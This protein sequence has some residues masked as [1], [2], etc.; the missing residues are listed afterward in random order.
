MGGAHHIAIAQA[1]QVLR[2]GG[3]V[4]FPTETVY[5]LG[6]DAESPA[7]V[8]KIFAAKGRPSAHPLIVHLAD[9][10]QLDAWAERV[11]DRAREL[12]MR[13]WP[14]PLTI[15]LRRS[16]RVCDEVTGGLPTVGLRVPSHPLAHDLLVAFGG[17]IAA[18][19]ANR[20]GAVSPTTADH[21]RADLGDAVDLVL[22]GGPCTV[23]LESTIVDLSRGD[24]EPV[25]LRA[26]G[27]DRETIAAILGCNVPLAGDDAVAS[28]G[29]LPSHYAPRAP[30]E[31]VDADRIDEAVRAHPRVKVG[32]LRQGTHAGPPRWH[33]DLDR[34]EVELGDPAAVAHDLY[35]TL[36]E[37]D[38]RGCAVIIA[39]LPAEQGLGLAIAD[40]LRKAAAPR[41]A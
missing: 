30:V 3:L 41:G 39:T 35:A 25:L 4:A 38:A 2:S 6:A 20:F 17:G 10:A 8:R 5:G 15:V 32:V 12:A 7:A 27:I 21:V 26:G 29:R 19:S 18:P 37:L 34:V 33:E 1:V 31:L 23:G 9:V 13:C 24:D 22:D 40:R 16:A 28:P 14:G 36:R 11:P